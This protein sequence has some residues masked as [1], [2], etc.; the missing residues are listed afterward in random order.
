MTARIDIPPDV[1]ADYCERWQIVELSLF[2][3]VLRDDFGPE[4]D[5]D[6]MVRFDPRARHT[7]FD[8]AGM[9][10]ELS[11]LLGRKT[12]L[13]ERISV[14]QSANYIRRKAILQS[15][16]TI[17]AARRRLRARHAAGGSR[18]KRIRRRPDFRSV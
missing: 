8:L 17:Y 2:G 14:E 10:D 1:I 6:V 12:D 18:G 9:Q 7:L 3:S 11:T 13:I 4:S 5:V 15:A 16:E